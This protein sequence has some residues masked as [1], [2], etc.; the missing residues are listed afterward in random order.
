M[1]SI[2]FSFKNEGKDN[3]SKIKSVRIEAKIPLFSFN[4]E[5]GGNYRF[6]SG[7]EKFSNTQ[8][9]SDN[10]YE[11]EIPLS[12]IA[13]KEM[14]DIYGF[15]LYHFI[16]ILKTDS[17]NINDFSFK[18]DVQ[19][20]DDAEQIIAAREFEGIYLVKS[21]ISSDYDGKT[22]REELAKFVKTYG[23][24]NFSDGT[25]SFNETGIANLASQ[26]DNRIFLI[27][28]E[29]YESVKLM[30]QGV[31]EKRNISDS[32]VLN[33]IQIL[34]DLNTGTPKVSTSETMNNLYQF[35]D[36]NKEFQ[37]KISQEQLDS[38]IKTFDKFF[39]FPL[40][41]PEITF[42]DVKGTF[43]I[44]PAEN[45]SLND[46]HSYDLSLEYPQK[47]GQTRKV[48]LDWQTVE[49]DSGKSKFNFDF[50]GNNRLI[51]NNIS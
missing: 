8:S 48:F 21:E 5:K 50:S 28:K 44:T 20:K 16:D 6:V 29:H 34:V 11:V 13:G 3:P 32:F 38:I 47:G 7:F 46:L 33:I 39:D 25:A 51:S 37:N 19:I 14:N 24:V 10:T 9:L 26:Y 18:F 45:I 12:R 4:M 43:E 40:T 30:L 22:Y 49:T 27:N 23:S 1:A 31:V 35:V 15:F 41:V 36:F 42:T 2:Q 17:I